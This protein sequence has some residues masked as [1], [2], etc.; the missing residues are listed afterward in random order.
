MDPLL[1]LKMDLNTFFVISL[2]L[3]LSVLFFWGFR[4]LPK[5]NWQILACVP[6]N[7]NRGDA[8]RGINYTW[9]GFFQATGYVLGVA[10]F[11]VLIGA[12]AVPSSAA[13]TLIILILAVCAPLSRILAGLVEGLS[14]IHI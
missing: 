14:L 8:W 2:G 4:G 6:M 3:A 5:E 11:L 1:F 12:V 7:K 13:L 9:Y 10:L